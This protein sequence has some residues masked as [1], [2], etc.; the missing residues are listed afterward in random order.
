MEARF[1]RIRSNE[2]NVAWIH[3]IRL[4][5]WNIVRLGILREGL[6]LVP[7]YPLIY[8]HANDFMERC[9]LRNSIKWRFPTSWGMPLRH[10]KKV[11]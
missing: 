7:R 8:Y 2:Q 6:F 11:I 10:T 3:T 4:R 5:N 9:L 1:L